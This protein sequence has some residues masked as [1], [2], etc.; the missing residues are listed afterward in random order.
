MAGPAVS[1]PWTIPESFLRS[2]RRAYLLLHTFGLAKKIRPKAETD[3]TREE[4]RRWI[5]SWPYY[6]FMK[7]VR[8]E[9]EMA[10]RV[11][12]ALSTGNQLQHELVVRIAQ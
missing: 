7:P 1:R 8:R 3:G 9:S 6:D 11:A 4:K 2:F 10:T 12:S 5:V